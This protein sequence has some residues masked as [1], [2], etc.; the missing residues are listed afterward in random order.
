[1]IISKCYTG[2]PD[3]AP[4]VLDWFAS[5]CICT[6]TEAVTAQQQTTNS[7]TKSA[8]TEK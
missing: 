1:M 7:R 3:P 5:P 2:C 8:T 4:C 6:K